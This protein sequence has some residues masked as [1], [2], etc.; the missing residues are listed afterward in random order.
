[1]MRQHFGYSA[2]CDRCGATAERLRGPGSIP[3]SID[4]HSYWSQIHEHR[5]TEI[6]PRGPLYFCPACAAHVGVCLD[7]MLSSFDP[8]AEYVE[9]L[10]SA[11]CASLVFPDGFRP[12][13]RRH[14]VEITI[15][16]GPG[17]AEDLVEAIRE[18]LSAPVVVHVLRNGTT[19]CPQFAG[20]PL[21][22][23]PGHTWAPTGG[24]FAGITCIPCLDSHRQRLEIPMTEATAAATRIAEL[25]GAD[26]RRNE[27][28]FARFLR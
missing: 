2:T 12:W 27:S 10:E 21:T 11:V 19:E 9:R 28:P 24:G 15:D 16:V 25:V 8:G 26:I 5:G 17:E 18:E 7:A 23:P 14:L 20:P 6:T 22:W 1:M 4:K 3:I 13:N